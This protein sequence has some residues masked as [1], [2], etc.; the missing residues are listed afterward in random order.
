M[1]RV[2]LKKV[3]RRHATIAGIVCITVIGIAAIAVAVFAARQPKEQLTSDALSSSGSPILRVVPNA[4]TPLPPVPQ[5]L[6]KAEK[7]TPPKVTVPPPPKGVEYVKDPLSITMIVNKK[8]QLRPDFAP[9]DL[10]SVAVARTYDEPLRNEAAAALEKM[11]TEAKAAGINLKMN[12]AYRSFATQQA[13]YGQMVQTNGAA[14]ADQ[15]SARP[16]FSEHQSG[17]AADVIQDAPT[18][19]GAA[20]A[21][22][23]A[24]GDKYGFIVRYQKGKEGITGYGYEP[25]HIRYVGISLAKQLFASGKTMEEHFGVPGGGYVN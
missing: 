25:W 12:S 15:Y 22:I 19:S 2:S 8:F 10:R 17:L 11:F 9:G 16:G 5:V 23:A 14:Y 13:V 6:P 21:W 4:D 20:A 7:T 24:N 3:S 1:A 18:T